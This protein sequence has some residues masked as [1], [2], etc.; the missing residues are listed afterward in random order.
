MNFND[1]VGEIFLILLFL[2]MA[3]GIIIADKIR[4]KK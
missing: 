2:G 3:I 4:R 1:L